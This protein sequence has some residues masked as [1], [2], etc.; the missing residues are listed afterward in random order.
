MSYITDN[1]F[2]RILTLPISLPQ[3]EIRRQRSIQIATF[4]IS[5]GQRLEMRSLNVHLAKI[6]T[7]GVTPTL[8]NSNLGLCSAGILVGS[9]ATSAIGSVYLN[10][11]GAA[12]FSADQPVIVTAP[13]VYRVVAFNN[14]NNVD[15]SLTV[16][17]SVKLFL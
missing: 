6:L 14:A 4:A 7:P 12:C 16:T 2:D 1:Q 13:G 5:L 9:M 3:T 11:L 10:G 15:L 8:D 17:G